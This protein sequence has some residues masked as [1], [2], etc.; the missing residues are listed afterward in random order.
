MVVCHKMINRATN[1][2]VGGKFKEA[3]DSLVKEKSL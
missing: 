1:C 3:K 2:G